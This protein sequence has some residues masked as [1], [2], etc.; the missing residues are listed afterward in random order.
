MYNGYKEITGSSQEINNYLLDFDPNDWAINEYLII[1][2][3]DDGKNS[4]MRWDGNQF[5]ALKLPP[6]SYV[7]AYNSEQRCLLD[8]LNNKNITVV[9]AL[10]TYGSGKTYLAMQMALYGLKEKPWYDKILGVREVVGEGR[11]IGFLPGEQKSKTENFFKPLEQQLKGGEFE[12]EGLVRAGQLETQIPYFLK[13][14]T[15]NGT[16]IIVDEA[17]D[18][19]EKQIKLIGTRAGKE[20]RVIFAGDYKQSIFNNTDSNPLVKMCAELR[21]NPLFGCVV[22]KEDVRSETS[23]LFAD[24]FT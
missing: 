24:L 5:V 6:S 4:E 21:G 17:E 11:D 12:L 22:L 23:K 13:G 19:T 7:K 9:A 15:Y 20:S 1:H 8:L 14:C 2:N 18:L 10:G 3:T 16:A